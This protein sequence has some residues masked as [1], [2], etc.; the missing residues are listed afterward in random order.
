[1]AKVELR[2]WGYRHKTVWHARSEYARNDDGDGFCEIHVNTMEGTWPLLRSWLGPDRG[3]S[4]EK[5]PL[6][7]AYSSH[8][9]CPA[10]RQSP[11]RCPCRRSGLV[12]G[13]ISQDPEESLSVRRRSGRGDRWRAASC[14]C[15]R[16]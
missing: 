14:R 2:A 8:A 12:M 7:S 16:P 1:M 10:P 6:I 3:I 5:L 13:P 11:P 4:Q 9:Q 15:H